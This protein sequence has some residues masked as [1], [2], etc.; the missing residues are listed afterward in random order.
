M[1]TQKSAH[2]ED[3]ICYLT[4]TEALKRFRER[5]LSPVELMAAVIERCE[6]VNPTVNA[7][8][9]RFYDEAMASARAA[10]KRYENGT[11]RPLEGIPLA[12]KELHPIKGMRTS[13]GSKIFENTPAE[14]TLPSIER[15][16]DAGAIVHIRTTTPEFAHAGHCHSPL[17]GI[18]RNPWNLDYSSCG[19][20]GGS[21]VAVAT[22]MATLATGDDGGGSI[23]MPASA[24]GLVG[25]KPPF[26]RNP[27]C[28]LD[29][30]FE[31]IL[32]V[33]VIT[34]SVNDSALAQNIMNGQHEMDIM[35]LPG[36]LTIPD[37]SEPIRELRIA[38]SP[39]LGYFEID[40]SVQ[41]NTEAAVEKLRELGCKVEEVNVA[42][43]D[44]AYDAWVTHW[45][46]LFATVAGKH[47][48]R[49]QYK[50]DPFV[51]GLIQRGQQ[52][53]AVR[54]KQT[55]MV[56]TEM[57]KELSSIFERY[58][59]LICPTL[60]VAGLAADH[61]NDDPNFQIN[62]KPVDAY[63]AWALTYPFNIL[64]QLPVMSVPTGMSSVGVP[65]GM[66]IITSPYDDLTAFQVA[67][68]YEKVAPWGGKHPK[69]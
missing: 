26:G 28:L 27:G 62:G 53:S 20:S 16:L 49:W 6:E 24:N 29:T 64:S 63:L 35:S 61:K 51:R 69:L 33:G 47:M 37:N 36:K 32:H 21:A 19:S 44:E 46:G 57:W 11:A 2:A 30:W 8:T 14:Y 43:T 68:A 3:N 58:D 55:E 56:R 31:M 5:S 39:N 15:L 13:W 67:R 48:T 40:P 45:E 18:T 54:V 22:G 1:S 7:I 38:Y 34:R 9:N 17:Y 41:K 42:W 4:A 60:G 25:F 12:S 65:T 50:M 10:E 23:R 66:Q 52:H 59:A